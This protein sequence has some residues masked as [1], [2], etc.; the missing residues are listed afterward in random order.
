[1][2]L[3]FAQLENVHCH[4]Y[5]IHAAG[6]DGIVAFEKGGIQTFDGECADATPFT[7]H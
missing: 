7:S 2:N 4:T 5:G 1:M 3:V 6:M